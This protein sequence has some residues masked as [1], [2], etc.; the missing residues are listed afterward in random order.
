MAHEVIMPVLG[1]NQDTGVI[2]AWTK[3]QGDYVAEGDVVMEVET[4]KAIQEITAGES[5][6][7]NILHPEGATVPVGDPVALLLESMDDAPAETSAPATKAEPDA[8]PA[9]TPTPAP[10]ASE[11]TPVAVPVKATDSGETLASPKA[12]AAAQRAGITL[13]SVAAASG[14]NVLHAADIDYFLQ[15]NGNASS[16][17]APSA[18]APMGMQPARLAITVSQE[19]LQYCETWL[20]QQADYEQLGSQ[21]LATLVLE[22][23]RASFLAEA[24][25]A[26]IRVDYPEQGAFQSLLL[27]DPDQ[28]RFSRIASSYEDAPWDVRLI[29]LRGS[30]ISEYEPG[31]VVEPLLVV[32]EQGEQL[33]V[34]LHGLA[35]QQMAAALYFMDQL[36]A[37]LEEPL[38]HIA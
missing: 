28:Q 24:E 8:A 7:L 23:W 26:V 30:R 33:Q 1:M 22:L 34:S 38:A 17:P 21:L 5:G 35:P 3:A 19:G 16:N 29:N 2:A 27:R 31:G 6:Y 4:D 15:Q 12:R 25:S 14:L 32:C 9:P 18:T 20:Q 36:A 37:Y 10:S 13:D 11:V